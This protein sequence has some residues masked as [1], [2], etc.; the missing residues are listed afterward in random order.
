MGKDEVFASRYLGD[1]VLTAMMVAKAA[2]RK[3]ICAPPHRK[4]CHDSWIPHTICNNNISLK[5]TPSG[6]SRPE[7]AMQ[8][9]NACL[10][11][12]AT[13]EGL[14]CAYAMKEGLKAFHSQTQQYLISFITPT[15][16]LTAL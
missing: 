8:S 2:D 16:S 1:L 12:P 5:T 13:Y 7:S 10:V 15:L 3:E 4:V 14:I 9:S 11:K 6:T